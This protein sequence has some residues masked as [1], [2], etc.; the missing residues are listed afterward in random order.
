[1]IFA[2]ITCTYCYYFTQ[3]SVMSQ[4]GSPVILTPDGGQED[5]VEI[6]EGEILQLHCESSGGRPA[7]EVGSLILLIYRLMIN[8]L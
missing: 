4:P 7:G 5:V 3:L 6:M 8:I 1:M 2:H